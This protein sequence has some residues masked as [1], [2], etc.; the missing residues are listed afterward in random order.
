MKQV[1]AL[2]LLLAMPAGVLAQTDAT[3]SQ[4]K[5]SARPS[6]AGSSS[7][8]I[9]KLKE[10]VAAQ[11]DAIAAQQQQIQMMQQQIQS[12]DQAIQTLQ[13]RVDQADS[14]ASQAQQTAQ[15]ALSGEQKEGE[16]S[17]SDFGALQ[18][19]VTDLKTANASAVESLTA[20]EKRVGDLES[21]LAIHFKGITLTPGGFVAADTVW[22]QHAMFSDIGTQFNAIPFSA[23]GQAHSS[24]FYGS[25]RASRM[26]LLAKGNW[27]ETVLTGYYEAD[28]LGVGVAST[29][30]Q[31]NSY[32]LRQRQ[33]WSQAA[34]HNGWS[35][36]GGQMWSLA[37][38]FKSGLDPFTWLSPQVVDT[39]YNVGFSYLRQYGVRVTKDFN[40]KVWFGMSV[41]NAQTLLTVS[42]NP[43]NFL[44][45][46]P[47]NG[48]SGGY[49]SLANYSSN[50]SPDFVA[51]LAFEPGFGHYEIFGI[52]S[53]FRTRIYPNATAAKP[54]AADAF[55]NTTEGGGLGAN[56]RWLVAQKHL[57][58]G[59]HYLG[60]NGVGRYGVAQLP[61]ATAY[62]NGY[63]HL[64]RSYQGLLSVEYHAP[65][66]DLNL[67]GGGEYAGRQAS[68]YNGKPVGY[69]S[70]LFVNTGC[71]TETL[72]TLANGYGPGALANCAGNTRAIFEGTAAFF[73]KFYNGPKGRLQLGGQYSYLSRDAWSGLGGQPE[74]VENMIFSSFRY[75]LP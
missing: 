17:A 40:N 34:F 27:G 25:G 47:G 65:K 42:G 6:A 69:G 26:S 38:E 60:G 29:N 14:A 53:L 10:A 44:I 61:D 18:H 63:E 62:G 66:W 28:F 58:I 23:S 37:T 32:V 22:R 2:A 7:S 46:G 30:N 48:S 52:A 54:S 11:T 74:A 13:K 31:S 57:E 1:L 75:Y 59:I 36:A 24:D 55:N 20:T 19:D 49:N 68:L 5:S 39:Q 12:R 9:Q 35:V 33:L 50:Y 73:Y 4:Q 43:T 70:P 72:P 64:V 3:T 16:I 21:P 8:E 51:K 71:G 41:E 15:S 67:Y 45:G 56:A